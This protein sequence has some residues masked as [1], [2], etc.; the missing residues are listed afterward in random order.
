M[1]LKWLLFPSN[2]LL[3]G[4]ETLNYNK[5]LSESKKWIQIEDSPHKSKTI[6]SVNGMQENTHQGNRSEPRIQ[7]KTLRI[8]VLVIMPNLALML[9]M[10]ESA[11]GWCWEAILLAIKS[12]HEVPVARIVI[13]MVYSEIPEWKQHYKNTERPHEMSKSK[14]RVP[15]N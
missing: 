12:G 7:N 13:A 4:Y 8:S 3:I 10:A 14:I 15:F 2:P 1:G 11:V 6:N 9:A 5:R